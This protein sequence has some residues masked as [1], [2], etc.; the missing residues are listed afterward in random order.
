M[1]EAM[2]TEKRRRLRDHVRE[3]V[4]DVPR[5]WILDMDADRVQYPRGFVQDAGRRNLLGLR[6]P[7]EYGGRGLRWEDERVNALGVCFC[8]RSDPDR[9]MFCQVRKSGRGDEAEGSQCHCAST[10][11]I[12]RLT[13]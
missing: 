5:Q 7:A 9:P 13:I 3:F 11:S 8:G 12:C 6:F 2:L 4:R 1:F 10:L